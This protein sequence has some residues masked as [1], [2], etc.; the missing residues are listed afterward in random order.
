MSPSDDVR[1]LDCRPA[2]AHCVF[3]RVRI[4]LYFPEQKRMHTLS[5]VGARYRA[6][7]GYST[8]AKV[9]SPEGGYFLNK[10][11]CVVTIAR[12]LGR[13]CNRSQLT[14]DICSLD[15][16]DRSVSYQLRELLKRHQPIDVPASLISNNSVAHLLADGCYGSVTLLPPTGILDCRTHTGIH[17][18]IQTRIHTYIYKYKYNIYIYIYHMYICICI[19]IYV[20]IYIYIFIFPNG[21]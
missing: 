13:L 5:G 2:F 9:R 21:K 11:V 14:L 1:C 18:G 7:V 8:A 12:L 16:T 17:T 4:G 3:G 19:C 15:E 6:A 20:Y 10:Q